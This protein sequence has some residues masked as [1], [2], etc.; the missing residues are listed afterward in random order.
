M[1]KPNSRSTYSDY[2]LAK[3]GSPVIQIN[4]N[5][6]QLS[7]RIDDALELWTEYHYDAIS[8]EF[9]I[10]KLKQEDLDNNYIPIDDNIVGIIS[11]VN[12]G[13]TIDN[14]M[15]DLGQLTRDV[16]FDINFGGVGIGSSV[17]SLGDFQTTMTQLENINM[18]FSTGLRWEYH[19]YMNRLV[20]HAELSKTMAVDEYVMI[21]LYKIIDPTEHTRVWGNRWLLNYGT[22][23]IGI[24][25]G[26][27][28]SKYSGVQLPGGIV[29]DGDKIFD[30]YMAEKDKLEEELELKYAFPVSFLVG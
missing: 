14:W 8:K 13:G 27:N 3:L 17:G 25:W 1:A 24:Q 29:L 16:A 10:Y 11:V 22:A 9:Y 18:A 26:S 7:D 19:Q 23:L 28:L 5:D 21:E 20:F 12:P 4:I 2:C 6:A 15:T 30:R